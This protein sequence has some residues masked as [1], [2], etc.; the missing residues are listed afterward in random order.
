MPARV[1]KIDVPK[2][3]LGEGPVWSERDQ[4]LYFVDIAS[5]R[6]QGYWPRTREHRSW[7]FDTFTGSLA[8]CKSGGL[9]VALGHRVVWFDPRRGV[10]SI[11]TIAVLED[12]RPDNRLNDGKVDPWGRFWVGSMQA[13]EAAH[14]GRLWCVAPDGT[15][16]LHRDGIGVSNSIAFDRERE[17]MYFADSTSKVI[18]Q[19]T[20]SVGHMPK[21][22]RPFAKIEAANPDGSCTD[23]EGYLWNAEWA[24]WRVVRYSP[25]GK[26]DRVIEIPTSRPTSCA[27]GGPDFRTLFITSAEY[28]M[29][30][31]EKQRDPEAGSLYCIDFEDVKGLPSDC[32]AI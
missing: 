15:S 25:D 6:L 2:S 26:V 30:P 29:S 28:K 11:R 32:F 5:H 17:R 23:S 21:E 22:W 1:H 31:G 24:G 20:L 9:I 12:D 13:D 18:E 16:T 19:C 4:C 3:V 7:Q 8:E 27:F 10:D 14:T